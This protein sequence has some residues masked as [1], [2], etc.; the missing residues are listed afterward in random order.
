MGWLGR[1]LGPAGWRRLSWW[2]E[3]KFVVAVAMVVFQDERVL[4]L[5]HTYRPKVPWGLPTG[6]VGRGETLEE[7]CRREL[8]EET[9]IKVA[10]WHLL[11]TTLSPLHRHLEVAFWTTLPAGAMPHPTSPEVDA[12]EFRPVGLAPETVLTG[13]R[14]LVELAW[15][16]RREPGV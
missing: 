3:P 2:L 10:D 15:Q 4:W 1:H 5:H 8:W 14:R 11:A 13:Q 12:F 16:I 6:F 7:A 9:R